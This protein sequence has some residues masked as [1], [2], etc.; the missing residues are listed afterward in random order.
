MADQ[1]M[2]PKLGFDMAE[3]RLIDWKIKVGDQVKKGDVIADIETDKATIEIEA[4]A[5]GKVLELLAQAGDVVAV[6]SPIATVGAE[7]EQV[8]S[9]QPG[10]QPKSAVAAEAPAD[11]QS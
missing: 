4:A 8:S 9:A 1:L 5:G 3:G 10:S 6:G 2:M 7:G 11:S